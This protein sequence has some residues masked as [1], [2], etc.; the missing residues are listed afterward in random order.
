MEKNKLIGEIFEDLYENAYD[1]DF[2]GY[3]YKEANQ[4]IRKHIEEFEEDYLLGKIENPFNS[5]TDDQV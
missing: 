4:I 3:H 5:L 1:I 2:H